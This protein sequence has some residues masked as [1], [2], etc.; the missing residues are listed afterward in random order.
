M[1]Y[2]DALVPT[3]ADADTHYYTVSETKQIG[4]YNEGLNQEVQ[5]HHDRKFDMFLILT[6]N[7]KYNDSSL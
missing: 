4:T 2:M 3:L 1:E 7:V 5:E 6:C